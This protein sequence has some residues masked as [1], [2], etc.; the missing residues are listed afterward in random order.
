[1]SFSFVLSYST[2]DV[3]ENLDVVLRWV[4]KTQNC[5][6]PSSRIRVAEPIR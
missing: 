6:V 5:R 3:M 4:C 2:P 1:M